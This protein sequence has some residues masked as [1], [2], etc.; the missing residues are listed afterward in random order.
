[1]SI[2]DNCIIFVAREKPPAIADGFIIVALLLTGFDIF[3]HRKRSQ[4]LVRK[5]CWLAGT[6]HQIFGH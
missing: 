6:V 4:F 5:R 1:M 3:F 2:L